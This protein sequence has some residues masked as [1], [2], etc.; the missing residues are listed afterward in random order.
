[1]LALSSTV[2]IEARHLRFDDPLRVVMNGNSREDL[3][4]RPNQPLTQVPSVSP[5]GGQQLEKGC[6]D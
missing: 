3:I 4:L 2:E 6:R 5:T 1:M